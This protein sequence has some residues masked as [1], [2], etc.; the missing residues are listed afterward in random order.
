MPPTASPSASA[1]IAETASGYH[2]LKIR[3][4]SSLKAIPSSQCLISG[5]FTVGGHRW[6]IIYYPNGDRAESAGHVSVF[7]FLDENVD[8]EVMARFQFGFKAEKKAKPAAGTSE[9][10]HSFASQ[11]TWGYTKFVQWNALEKSK[12]LKGDSFT[13]RCDLAVVKRVRI[14]GTAQEAA[15]KF[16]DVPPSDLKQHLSGL[17]LTGSG[18]DVVFEAGGETFAAHRCVLA[19]RSP[20]FSAELFGSMKEGNT[21]DLV[22]IDG[23]EAQ[24]FKALLCFVYTD[25]LPEMGKEE[26]DAMC[27]HLL[28][29]DTYNLE[30]MKLVCEDKLCKHINVGTAV[31]ILALAELH[32]CPGLKTA[33]IHFL[34]SRANLRAAMASDGFEHLSTTCPSVAKELIAMSSAP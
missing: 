9:A 31:N 15:P 32:G 13:I 16:V 3:G 21:N 11:G 17:F 8:K 26:E 2:H 20:V 19:A 1:I 5:P 24:V 7:L 14:E 25:S 10:A 6:R 34:S 12:H 29:A 4:Y 27:Q 30:R 22:R 33:C 28:V 18:A 23:M